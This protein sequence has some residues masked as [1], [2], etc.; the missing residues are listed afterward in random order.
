MK[1]MKNTPITVTM[2][3]DPMQLGAI[4]TAFAAVGLNIPITINASGDTPLPTPASTPAAA[5]AHESEPASD[6]TP[7]AVNVEPGK[8]SKIGKWSARDIDRELAGS[9]NVAR[10]KRLIAAYV[11]QNGP[12]SVA[13]IID[14]VRDGRFKLTRKNVENAVYQLQTRHGWMSKAR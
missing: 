5:D 2:T 8:Y 12:A 6:R 10:H 13:D 7:R 4:T 1:T 14:N 11:L 3:I 9:S